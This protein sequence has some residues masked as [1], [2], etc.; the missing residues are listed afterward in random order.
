MNKIILII[1]GIVIILGG[2][3]YYFLTRSSLYGNAPNNTPAA[4][5]VADANTAN[6]AMSNFSF[7]PAEITIKAGMKVVWTNNDLAGH[8]IIAD[9]GSFISSAISQEQ[10]FERVFPAAGIF[11]YH[12]KIHPS[13]TGKVIVE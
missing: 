3:V 1:I 9:D 12:C 13:M 5:P 10:T 8:L 2:G 4:S 11:P 6:V 7:K